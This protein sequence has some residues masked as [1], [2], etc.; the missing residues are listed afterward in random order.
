MA[1]GIERADERRYTLGEIAAALGVS[2]RAAERRS[3]R[4]G[5]PFTEEPDIGGQRRLFALADLPPDVQ[6]ALLLREPP[7]IDDAAELPPEP[8]KRGRRVTYVRSAEQ[9]Q[10]IWTR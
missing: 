9:I 3:Q 4:A 5:W 8:R 7:A 6:A 10:S 2:K 1:D